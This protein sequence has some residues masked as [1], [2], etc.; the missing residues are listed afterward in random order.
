MALK[1]YISEVING[2]SLSFDEAQKAMTIIMTG[3]A[4][5]A[6][7]GSYLTALRMKGE[8]VEEVGGSAAAM[9]SLY[10]PVKLQNGKG[11]V[12]DVVGTGGDGRHTFN[13]STTTAFVV[14]GTGIQI[15]KHG[16]RAASSRSGS[17]DVL[18]ALGARI[19]LN[20]KQ[21][22]DCIDDVGIGFMYAVNHHP[23]MR[24]AIGP[25]RELG[26]R[27]IFNLLG[28]LTNP[29]NASH[30]MMGVF[31]PSLTEQMA[32]ALRDLGAVAA[33]VVHGADGLD[34]LSITGV[35]KVTHLLNGE[36]E[37]FELDPAGLGFDYGTLEDLI[38]GTPD[39]N[40]AITRAILSGEETGP[41]RDIVL[42]NA[43]AALALETRDFA[44]GL[45]K[46]KASID[47]GAAAK[48]L[49]AWVAKTNQV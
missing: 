35:N 38:G 11:M 3:E 24:F 27:T 4:T 1:P 5:Q 8:T 49:D 25:R 18:M 29:A 21:V 47:S 34:E 10:V 33:F 36:I 15:A 46:A 14:A 17:A 26:Q 41:K 40:A 28:P 37:T 22:G 39:E 30:Y 2:R 12:M 13:I 31:A 43:A 6:Q 7:I 44:A 20:S 45:A 19:D 16:N 42:L 9:R 23:A 48:M 32:G